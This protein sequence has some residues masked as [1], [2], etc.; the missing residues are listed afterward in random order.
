MK[1]LLLLLFPLITHSQ[2]IYKGNIVNKITKEK[3]PFATVGLTKENIGTNADENGKFSL[4]SK[5]YVTDSLVISCVGYETSKFSVDNLPSNLQFEISERQIELRTIIVKNNF[6]SSYTLNDYSNCGFNSYTSSGSVT[7]IAQHLQS[8][9]AN[10]LLSEIN[11]CK[12]A[13]NS[14]F[15]IRVYD[16]D[17]ISGKPSFDLAD[18]II[19]VK[20]GKRHVKINL[21]KYN[22]VIPEKDFFVG[23]EWLYIPFN[24]NNVK[25][26]KDGQK[27]NYSRY[28][29]FIF[30]RNRG[31]NKDNLEKS[32]EAWQLDFR[33]K[34]IRMYQDWVF[35]ISATVKY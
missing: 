17:P 25:G 20:S 21:E 7:Q 10:S 22:I 15:R 16:M 19:E 34:W 14:L 30:F 32:L 6:K 3:I 31:C 29:P 11:I 33:R 18:T 27:I 9:I 4:T 5:K 1:I 28:N 2:I 8:P 23:I 13:D 24:E 26:K 35:L 12:E